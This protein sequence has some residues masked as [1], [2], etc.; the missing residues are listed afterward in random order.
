MKKNNVLPG[1]GY[2]KTEAPTTTWIV[3]RFLEFPETGQ[4]VQ[5]Y[6]KDHPRRT[7][8][9]AVSALLDKKM[10]RATEAA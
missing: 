8:T 1:A 5:L 4:H 10:F 6:Q 2:F 7:L 3:S 9:V